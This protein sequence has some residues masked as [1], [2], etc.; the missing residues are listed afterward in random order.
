VTDAALAG[1]DFV[2][3]PPGTVTLAGTVR[4]ALLLES[5]T[6]KPAVRAWPLSETVQEMLPATLMLPGEQVKP[7][8]LAGG[9]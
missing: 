7:V 2:V 8:N 9:A 1:K 4:L 6:G 3:E 5:A